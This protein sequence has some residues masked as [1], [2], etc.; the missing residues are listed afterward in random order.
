MAKLRDEG[1]VFSTDSD[2]EVLFS[3]L[4]RH[5]KSFLSRLDG[6][7]ALAFYDSKRTLIIARSFGD[8]RHMDHGEP[9]LMFSSEIRGLLSFVGVA[10]SNVTSLSALDMAQE[11]R[12]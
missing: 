3:G 2:T 9:G 1:E 4:K 11:R 10:L 5:G 7:F 6:M 8:D 12:R